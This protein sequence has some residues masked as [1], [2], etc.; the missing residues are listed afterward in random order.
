MGR[1]PGRHDAELRMMSK[2]RR[3]NSRL[4]GLDYAE[5]GRAWFVTCRF[6]FQLSSEVLAEL[7]ST[8]LT[9]FGETSFTCDALVVMPDHCHFV[10]Q[11]TTLNSES[12]GDLLCRL[13]SKT[14][15]V[16]KELRLVTGSFWQKNYYEH[17]I[18]NDRDWYEKIKYIQENPVRACLV[19]DTEAY[20]HLYVRHLASGSTQGRPLREFNGSCSI[21]R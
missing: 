12:L 19:T 10:T 9:V 18:R 6:S 4:Q 16:L 3:K 21:L 8:M 1:I 14:W 5:E 17:G 13:K 7:H 20:P 2:D 11:K 15:F